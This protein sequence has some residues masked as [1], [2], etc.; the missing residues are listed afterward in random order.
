MGDFNRE[1]LKGALGDIEAAPKSDREAPDFQ[2]DSF[3]DCSCGLGVP[4]AELG[5]FHSGY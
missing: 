4:F 5:R 2:T 1:G 3:R